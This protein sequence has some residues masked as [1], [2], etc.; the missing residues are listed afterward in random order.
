MNKKKQQIINKK[1]VKAFDRYDDVFECLQPNKV[2]H[3]STEQQIVTL[4]CENGMICQIEFCN[5]QIIKIRYAHSGVLAPYFSYAIS[6]EF[7]SKVVDFEC[8]E[9]ESCISIKSKNFT[10]QVNKTDA[11]L[12]FFNLYNEIICEQNAPFEAITTMMKGTTKVSLSLA[13]N[14]NEQYYGL[15][16]KT[17]DIN[18]RG[19]KF[20]NWCTD[21][22]GFSK[23]SDPL[24]RA[25]PFFITQAPNYSYGIFLDNSY[26]SHFDFGESQSSQLLIS[27]DGGEMCFYFIGGNDSIEVAE[28]YMHLT[29]KPEMP[30]IWALGFHQCR[31]SYYPEKRVKEVA[32]EFRQRK[33]PCD[34]IYLDIDYM[35]G[36][37]C[38]TIN[39]KYFPDLQS[40]TKD[41]AKDNFEMVVMIDPGIKAEKGYHVYEEG[42]ENDAFCKRFNG[43]LMVGPVW[44][45]ACVFPDYTNEKVR[46][47][48]GELYR[49]LYNHKGISGFWNDMNEPAL[50]NVH[51]MT[52]PD[53]VQH[54][55]EGHSA[56]HAQIHNVYG[57]QMSRA[58]IEGLKHLQPQKRPFLLTRAT[59]SGGQRYAAVWTG[60]NFSTWEHLRYANLQ[61]QR[62]SLSGFS[63]CGSDIGGFAGKPSGELMVRWLQLSVFHPLMRIHSMG[64]HADGASAV[65]DEAVQ[66]A[67]AKNRMDQEPWAYGKRYTRHAKAAIEL[68]YR[69]LPYLYT[70]FYHNVKQGT[71]IIKSAALFEA[72]YQ[73][74]NRDFLFGTQLWVSPIEEKG[75]KQQQIELPEG[76][77]FD[78]HKHLLCKGSFN[79]EVKIDSI[80]FFVK[81][82]AVLPLAPIR[83]STKEKVEQMEL[84]VYLTPNINDTISTFYED[85]GEGYGASLLR[86]FTVRRVEDGFILVQHKEG[87]YRS[88]YAHFFVNVITEH[89]VKRMKVAEDFEQLIL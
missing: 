50:F 24:Y 51:R 70:A 16:D 9:N 18:L 48:W 54:D 59:F 23:N 44:P 55:F 8:L 35:S 75:I 84:N 11:K 17:W 26:R 63:F 1:E 6:P 34:A 69:L 52:F 72:K 78:F 7:S 88:D 31:W 85:A 39:E 61:A 42:L 64:N 12:S 79:Y 58:T 19:K 37:R 65:D 53:E 13:M 3:F 86:T 20:Q 82:G 43:E 30:P 15:G 22:F 81:A 4:T 76:D 28:N 87:T 62:L 45:P 73:G 74:T 5:D 36:Y 25:I 46:K 83:Q 68:R 67:E 38:F 33:I 89:G 80:P 21:A 10:I 27:A 40:L 49:D 29:G 32:A 60:D 77:W 66:E 71:P 57:M 56:T 41:L 47:W 14:D 2:H